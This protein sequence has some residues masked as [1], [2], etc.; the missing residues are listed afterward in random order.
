MV[1]AVPEEWALT[2]VASVALGSGHGLMVMHYNPGARRIAGMTR[3]ESK[4]GNTER[5]LPVLDHEP[6]A[7]GRARIGYDHDGWATLIELLLHGVQWQGRCLELC[8]I[9]QSRASVGSANT[10][11]HSNA[12]K[13]VR[14]DQLPFPH[15]GHT[16]HEQL[17]EHG[18]RIHLIRFIQPISG[19]NK[20]NHTQYAV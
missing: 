14:N 6:S 2:R 17:V 7:F 18:W 11:L 19:L 9:M 16:V 13:P 1:Q 12:G 20:V 10:P 15:A 3:T 4:N 5:L 8:C